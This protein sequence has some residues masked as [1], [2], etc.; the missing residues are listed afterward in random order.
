VRFVVAFRRLLLA[1]HILPMCGARLCGTASPHSRCAEQGRLT[2]E[3]LQLD[4]DP[5]LEAWER[6]RSERVC[7][8]QRVQFLCAVCHSIKTRK[9]QQ[10]AR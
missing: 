3:G 5:P 10:Q 2:V 9:E 7:D 6:S 1:R 4:H 8:P